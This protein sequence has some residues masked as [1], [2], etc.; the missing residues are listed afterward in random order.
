MAF[1][2]RFGI[3]ISLIGAAFFA[4]TATAKT[5]EAVDCSQQ[6][7]QKAID[8]AADGNTVLVPSGV[9]IWTTSQENRP[10]VVMSRKGQEKRITLKGAGIGKTVIIDD[11]GP[12]CFQVVIK[13]SETGIFSGVE[14]KAFRITGFTFKGN[15]GDALLFASGYTNWRIDHCRFENSGRSLWVS[16]IGLIDHCVFDKRDNGQSIFVSHRDY[17]D[18]PHG[19][20]SWNSPLALGTEKA[21]YIEDCTFRYY[22]QNPNA[23]LDGCFGA[24]IVFRHNT[25]VNASIAVH[26]TESS[27]RGRSIRSYEIYGNRFNMTPPKEHFTAIFLRGGTGVIFDNKLTGAYKAFVLATNYRSRDS[28]PPWGKCDGSSRWDGNREPNGYPAIDQIGRSTDIGPG[29]PQQHDPLYEWDN[30]LNGRDADIAVSGGP[31]VQAHIKEGRD[32]HN[33]KKRPEYSPY[34]YPHPLVVYAPSPVIVGIEWAP[35]ETIIRQAK[36]SD[37]WPLT[38]ADDGHLYTTW[39]DGNGFSNVPRRSMGY[40]KIKAYPPHHVGIDIRSKQETFGNGK[41]GK[42][43]WGLLC[44][45]GVLYLWMGHADQRGGQAQ[46]AW[47][48]DHAKTWA[49]ANWKF[50]EF[51]LVGFVNFGRNYEG[52]RDGYVYAYSHDSPKADTPADRFILMR[53]PKDRIVRRDAYEFIEGFTSDGQPTWTHDISRRAAV[54]ERRD[55]CLRSAMTYH[56]VLKRYLWWQQVAQPPG[57]PDRGDTRFSGGFGIYDAPEPW[58]PWTTVFFTQRWDVGPGEHADFPSKWMSESG[59]TAY[60]AFSGDDH[61]SVRMAKFKLASQ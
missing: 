19:D 60:L 46:L 44:V 11:T 35:K 47:S 13:T 29:T 49:C 54:F 28:Y 6:E 43:G 10:A 18:K 15:G 61:F 14:D 51:G 27:G 16:G 50:A 53:V 39:G 58:G 32:Y 59:T 2:L 9:S 40:A 48:R 8:A 23:A 21:V 52:A 20:G 34:A 31:E 25:L 1:L 37:N 57:A 42:K 56:P 17:A 30:R 36:G 3:L 45:E 5:I 7:V 24:R 38:W 12:A 26:G 4:A 22:V 55:S 33:D 41:S